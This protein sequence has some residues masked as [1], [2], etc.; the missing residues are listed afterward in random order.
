M[1][2]WK[3]NWPGRK[4]FFPELE[5]SLMEY[6]SQRRAGG[7]A[8]STVELRLHAIR[9]TR[10]IDEHT[11]FKASPKWCFNFMKRNG[12]SISRRTSIAQRLPDTFEDKLLEY[13]R[14][15]LSLRKRQGYPD[16]LIA[17]A[18]QTPPLTFDYFF[19]AVIDKEVKRSHKY[20]NI[21]T[22]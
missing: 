16:A 3:W 15:I 19:E 7:C 12:I 6:I 18:D 2:K 14:Y 21:Y 9:I 4:A 20:I 22:P 8:I 10:E 17:N 13:Q 1:G 11:K 5:K